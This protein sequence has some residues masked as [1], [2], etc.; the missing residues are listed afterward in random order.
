VGFALKNPFWIGISAS[1]P[2]GLGGSLC[3]RNNLSKLVGIEGE[4]GKG[5]NF[6]FDGNCGGFLL[7]FIKKLLVSNLCG[8]CCRGREGKGEGLFRWG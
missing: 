7:F 4:K 6:F 3:R 1:R 5:R 8:S 2:Q